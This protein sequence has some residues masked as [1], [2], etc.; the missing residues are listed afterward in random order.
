MGRQIG[1]DERAESRLDVGEKKAEPVEGA[2]AR[3]W[4]RI[5]GLARRT[6]R[7]SGVAFKSQRRANK[8]GG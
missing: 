4:R 3:A 5:D 1:G 8:I 6:R 7:G 2:M